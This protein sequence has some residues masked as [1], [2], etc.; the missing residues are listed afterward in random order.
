MT[1]RAGMRRKANPL[2]FLAAVCAV[3]IG[4]WLQRG[5]KVAAPQPGHAPSRI[6][7]VVPDP[8]ERAQV[9]A[10]I[11]LIE[12]GGPFPHRQ[13]GTIFGNRESRLPAQARDYYREYT[14]PT[15]GAKDRGARRLIRGQAGE[16][17]YTRDH[18]RTFMKI[19]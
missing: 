17:Y 4:A 6:E 7:Q 8:A 18:Y 12:R 2:I 19:D 16:L 9:L 11:A 15:P 5:E 14:V 10:T 1:D 3:L 13:D